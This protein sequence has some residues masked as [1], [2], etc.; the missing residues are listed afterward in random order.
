M[1]TN[2]AVAMDEALE[3][4]AAP[5]REIPD[6]LPEPRKAEKPT[7]FAFEH[8]VFSVKEACFTLSGLGEPSYNVPLGDVRAT[9]PVDTV[10]ASFSIAKDSSDSYLLQI[11][12]SSLKFVKEIRPGDSIPSEILNGTASWKVEPHH[13]DIAK[14]RIS[15]QLA[16][17][18]GGQAI[19]TVKAQEIETVAAL[20]ET[21]Q[22]VQE[23][24]ET[25]ADKLG[26]G[27]ANKKDV[28][29]KFDEL[30]RE[31]AYIEA[32]RERFGRIQRINNSVQALSGIYAK[33]RSMQEELMRVRILM[34]KP[35]DAISKIFQD[36]DT[37]TGDI[38]NT[39]KR[40]AAQ[41]RYIRETRDSLHQR[42]MQW[43]SLIEQ[44]TGVV[45]ER[46]PLLDRLIRVTYQF[47]ARHFPQ[48][49]D[50]GVSR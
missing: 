14:A 40:F 33:E 46:T 41:V 24:I 30:A 4:P 21:K 50:W 34:K 25:M 49:S 5:A 38:L 35:V 10:A 42:F 16:S 23:A 13:R 39:M 3:A 6:T 37:N 29:D 36:V 27:K 48:S 32:L 31:M 9:L 44:W 19:D 15:V 22:R 45:L 1:P 20:P 11:V 2:L 18:M 12:K 43:D 26:F 8:A 7:H 47:T 28:V 17:W